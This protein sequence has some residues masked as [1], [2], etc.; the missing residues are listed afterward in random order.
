MTEATHGKSCA[1]R[2]FSRVVT[3]CLSLL[4]VHNVQKVPG[5][6]S[7]TQGSPPTSALFLYN[8]SC[9]QGYSNQSRKSPGGQGIV[10]APLI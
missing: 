6:G 2:L 10:S 3:T 9:T 5:K 8:P 1:E 4:A 7:P